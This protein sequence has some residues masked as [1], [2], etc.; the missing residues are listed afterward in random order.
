MVRDK[1]STPSSV[2]TNFLLQVTPPGRL[3]QK[4]KLRHLHQRS[5]SEASGNSGYT[6]KYS[7]SESEIQ[8]TF[9][10]FLPEF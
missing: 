7:K 5:F 4:F 2:T 9:G 8:I 10:A 6:I 3:R 1:A